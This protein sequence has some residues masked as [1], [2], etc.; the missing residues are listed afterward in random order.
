MRTWSR[1]GIVVARVSIAFSALCFFLYF[2][3]TPIVL[4]AAIFGAVG[5]TLA[6]VSK[7][8]RTALVTLVFALVPFAQLMVEVSFDTEGL[9]FVPGAIAIAVAAWALVDHSLKRRAVE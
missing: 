4:V 9:I 7:A 8:W 3:Y 1:V 5:A 2:G 6:A